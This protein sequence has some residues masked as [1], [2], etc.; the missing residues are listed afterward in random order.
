MEPFS[1][2]IPKL[3]L[4]SNEQILKEFNSEALHFLVVAENALYTIEKLPT[5]R[6]SIQQLFKIF[7]TLKGLAEFLELRDIGFLCKETEKFLDIIRKEQRKFDGA[8]V[9][10]I[11]MTITALR[12]L[13]LLLGEQI[14]NRGQLKSQYLDIAILLHKLRGLRGE[15]TDNQHAPQS[16]LSW[17]PRKATEENKADSTVQEWEEA[18]RL[19]EEALRLKDK[20]EKM[21]KQKGELLAHMAHEIRNL[22][23]SI[24][25]FSKVLQNSSLTEK[26]HEQLGLIISSSQLLLEVV[27]DILDFSKSE[28]G[29]LKLEAIPF[30]LKQVL[31][32]IGKILQP[33]LLNKPVRFEIEIN[34]EVPMKL[35][36]DPTKLRQILINLL[37]N[38]IKFTSQ[39]KV[40]LT[41]GKSPAPDERQAVLEFVIEDTGIGIA[42]DKIPNLFE[43]FSQADSFI[44]RL[45]GGSGLGLSICKKYIE[46]MGGKIWVQSEGDKGS[47]FTFVLPFALASTDSQ[48]LLS[49]EAVEQTSCRGVKILVV[50]D[51]TT[52]LE[53]MQAYFE[54]MG[55]FGDYVTTGEGAITKLKDQ[56]YDIC[57]MDLQMP[58]L[59]GIETTKVIRK[60]LKANL[61]VIALTGEDIPEEK[62]RGLEAGMNDFLLKPFDVL[63]LK[64]MIIRYA[65]SKSLDTGA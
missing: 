17:Q 30:H 12:K 23:N 37:D 47:R 20:A 3:D 6:A 28:T 58:G 32:E 27:N 29:K 8:G 4:P 22:V 64:K 11:S 52:N 50:D 53:L 36:G 25:G 48:K 1:P 31:E 63:D 62:E 61:P 13:I 19:R 10:T 56:S 40:L 18:L 44:S 34:N 55:C 9:V 21:A 15:M 35:I 60:Q 49:D 65:K 5:D 14:E 59:D 51:S 33:K 38:A 7:H 41:V 57:F 42:P 16:P 2:Q 45:Y 39:G 26:Q 54:T 43:S 46:L 24:L